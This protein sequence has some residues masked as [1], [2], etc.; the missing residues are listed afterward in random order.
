MPSVGVN[1]VL[2]RVES[3]TMVLCGGGG[4]SVELTNVKLDLVEDS[5]LLGKVDAGVEQ[6]HPFLHDR[7]CLQVLIACFIKSGVSGFLEGSLGVGLAKP[8]DGVC[9]CG[10]FSCGVFICGDMVENGD[11]VTLFKLAFGVNVPVINFC[12]SFVVD[13]GAGVAAGVGDTSESSKI[14]LFF[15]SGS[16]IYLK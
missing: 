4:V 3:L 13:G 5:V 6:L 7:G 14:L 10:V 15:G 1:G 16:G 11:T 2:T 12:H 9:N 8:S